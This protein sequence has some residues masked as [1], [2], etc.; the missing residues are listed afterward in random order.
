MWV[1][2]TL[3]GLAGFVILA[4]CV[5]LDAALNIESPG[6]PRFR[7]KLVWLFGLVSKEIRREKKPEEKPEKKKGP[8]FSTI[9]KFLRTRGLLRK[10]AVL[11]RDIL[12]QFKIRELA[13]NCRLGL[14]D[15]ADTGLIFALIEA[16]TPFINHPAKYQLRVQPIFSDEIFLNGHLHGVVS[17]RPIGLVWPLLKFTFSPAMFGVVNK[18]VLSRWKRKK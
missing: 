1:I 17:V 14:N 2:A 13:L 6:R 15:P 8:D 10:I 5:P 9:L 11:V 12:G 3:A 4:L 7:L 18:V 16:T